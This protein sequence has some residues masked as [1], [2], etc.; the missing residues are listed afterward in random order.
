M[1]KKAREMEKAIEMEKVRIGEG[2]GERNGKRESE[3]N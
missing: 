1:K 3:R 2:K